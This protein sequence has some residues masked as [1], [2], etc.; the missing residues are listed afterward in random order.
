MK[1]TN[2]ML[3][4]GSPYLGW[5]LQFYWPVFTL[6][7]EP[8][9]VKDRDRAYPHGFCLRLGTT[10]RLVIGRADKHYALAAK[11]LGFGLGIQY[12]GK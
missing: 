4:F 9:S 1:I 5:G 11:V 10:V 2:G 8:K 6:E 3:T 7:W 12:L